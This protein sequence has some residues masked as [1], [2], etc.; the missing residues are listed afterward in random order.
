MASRIAVSAE[1]A[2]SVPMSRSAVKPAH[3]IVLGG[4]HREDGALRHGFFD[5]LQILSAGMQKQVHVRVD[6][7]G[8]QRRVAEVDDLGIRTCSTAVPTATMRSPSTRTS[9]GVCRRPVSTSRRW[10]ACRMMG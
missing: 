2:P 1:P 10:A 4:A 6:E 5:G 3:Q 8:H 7:T 9:P